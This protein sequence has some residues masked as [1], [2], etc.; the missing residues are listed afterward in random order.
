MG[1][2]MN[3]TG[4]GHVLGA[5]HPGPEVGAG[6][7]RSRR[8]AARG[9]RRAGPGVISSPDWWPS[10]WTISTSGS[11]RRPVRTLD[12]DWS[13]WP[14]TASTISSTERSLVSITTASVGLAQRRVVPALVE[15]VAAGQVGGHRLVVQV[16]HLLG[17]ARGPD[18]G[19]GVEVHLE[20][21][22]GEHHRA[23]V[24][25]LHHAAAALGGPLPLAAAHLVAH[26]GVGGHDAH[27]PGHLGAADLDGGVDAVDRRPCRRRPCAGR[28]R[29]PPG[30][31]A[32]RRRGRC[33][34]AWR[35]R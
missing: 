35:R 30:P 28:G 13:R 12:G 1:D 34:G 32:R 18:L 27:G 20:L 9:T 23:D 29:G 19:A 5:G 14:S 11:R 26:P 21:G 3:G 10:S 17:P 2:R 31:P 25:A 4:L 8:R 24:A 6:R 16:G 22:V 33:P 15:G 7:R